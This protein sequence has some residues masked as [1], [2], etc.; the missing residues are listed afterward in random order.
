MIPRESDMRISLIGRVSAIALALAAAPI[1]AK[2]TP[3]D[4]ELQ[5][6]VDVSGSI[7]TTEFN[8]QKSGYVQEFQNAADQ[9]QN[10]TS[11]NLCVRFLSVVPPHPSLHRE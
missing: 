5:L 10:L 7:D 2:A 9:A 1:A 6:L 8:L 11:L 3:V 4:I